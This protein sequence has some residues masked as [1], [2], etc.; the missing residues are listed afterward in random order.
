LYPDLSRT[1]PPAPSFIGRHSTHP[2]A[3]IS[4]GYNNNGTIYGATWVSGKHGYALSFDGVDDYVDI[5]DNPSLRTKTVESIEAF[6][7][8]DAIGSNKQAI[9]THGYEDDLGGNNVLAIDS[10]GNLYFHARDSSTITGTTIL[11]EGITYH[12]AFTYDGTTGKLYVN[13]QLDIS[14][15]TI[16]DVDVNGRVIIGRYQN[17]LTGVWAFPFN[18]IIDG[19]RIYS[20]VLSAEEIQAH[21]L[22]S[23]L[24]KQRTLSVV[25]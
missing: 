11:H 1:V 20:R 5:P 12:V 9:I 10:N 25:R 23:R 15:T 21:Y 24:L 22:G 6:I 17:P 2:S 18:G 14:G 3:A 7:R 13:G 8:I 16:V 4:S 19:V